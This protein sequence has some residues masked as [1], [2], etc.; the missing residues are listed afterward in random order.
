MNGEAILMYQLD[1][2]TYMIRWS[3]AVLLSCDLCDS[4]GRCNQAGQHGEYQDGIRHINR[5]R[6]LHLNT[7][8]AV[9]IVIQSQPLGKYDKSYF[10]VPTLA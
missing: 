4:G 8:M 10:P 6:K 5:D 2:L 9:D 3:T 1:H 7:S